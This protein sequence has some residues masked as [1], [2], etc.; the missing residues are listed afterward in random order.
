MEL[1]NVVPR[2]QAAFGLFPLHFSN[3]RNI[4][5]GDLLPMR[6]LD[7]YNTL[8]A[9]DDFEDVTLAANGTELYFAG[10]DLTRSG[11]L[12]NVFAPPV[13]FGFRKS[14]RLIITPLDSDDSAEVVERY[15]GGAWDIM[16]QGI[17]VD[18]EGHKFPLYKT[19]QLCKFFDYKGSIA[20]SGKQFDIR[21]IKT[22][23]F[24]E[25]SDSGVQGFQDT[26]QFTLTAR[27]IKPLDFYLNQEEEQ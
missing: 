17:L 8:G 10:G 4:P 13:M 11:A 21:G 3:D 22:I 16:M 23:Y 14:K 18:M 27:S 7:T 24:Q 20:V 19:E 26:L 1:I 25:Y 5:Y 6:P 9:L 12:G 15:N 2:L